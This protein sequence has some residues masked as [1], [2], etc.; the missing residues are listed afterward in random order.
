MKAPWRGWLSIAFD[1]VCSVR[2][3]C[4]AGT[5][6][7]RRHA[8]GHRVGGETTTT[9]GGPR[10]ATSARWTRASVDDIASL[11][12]VPRVFIYELVKQGKVPHVRVGRKI[13]IPRS[14]IPDVIEAAGGC[15]CSDST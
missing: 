10:C 11:F 15:E 8:H 3:S 6:V 7:C 9:G 2:R 12:K 4:D 5:Y 1:H 13:L 14:A